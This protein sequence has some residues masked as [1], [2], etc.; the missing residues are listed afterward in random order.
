MRGKD[1][2][3]SQKEYPS[4][5]CGSRTDQNIP[6]GQRRMAFQAALDRLHGFLA[7]RKALLIHRA[8][9]LPSWM[10]A[11]PRHTLG[12]CQHG[13]DLDQLRPIPGQFHNTPPPFNGSVFAVIGRIIQQVEGFAHG[14][15]K[16]HHAVQKLW[17][18]TT[19]CWPVIPF[20]LQPCHGPL[21]GLLSRCPPGFER[22]DDAITGLGRAPTSDGQLRAVFIH[23]PARNVLFLQAQ[24]VITR[25]V[26]A[27]CEAPA[28]DVT[29]RNGRLTIDTE[30][31]DAG[32][33]RCSLVFFSILAKIASVSAIFF[34]GLA[35]T[36]LR[37]RKP[38]RWSTA[39]MV[40]G[41]GHGAAL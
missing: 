11:L 18:N 36:T 3:I 4:S 38:R 20:E 21:L 9:Q 5:Q 32:R 27:P 25:P 24:V 22:I 26:I 37:H 41:A 34:C 7:Q 12:P 39:A 19:A 1:K 31:G 6:L 16:G 28:G 8:A 29:K 2:A 10:E 35:L 30:T 23:N 17:T 40:L 15:A 14:I 13:L 33:G